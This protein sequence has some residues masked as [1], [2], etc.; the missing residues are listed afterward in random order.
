L[1]DRLELVDEPGKRV[2]VS[3]VSVI[4]RAQFDEFEALVLD[5]HGRAALLAPSLSEVEEAL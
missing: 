4:R 2:S 3:V 5:D 1:V